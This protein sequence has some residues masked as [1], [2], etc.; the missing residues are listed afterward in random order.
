VPEHDFCL[1]TRALS[2]GISSTEPRTDGIVDA[3]APRK[4]SGMNDLKKRGGSSQGLSPFLLD[5]LLDPYS[6]T[7]LPSASI[8]SLYLRTLKPIAILLFFKASPFRFLIHMHL[9]TDQARVNVV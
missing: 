5:L 4:K 9:K 6:I 7:G 3:T 1:S 8:D 2:F